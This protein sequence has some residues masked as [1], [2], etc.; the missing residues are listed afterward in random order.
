[1]G[2]VLPEMLPQKTETTLEKV[3]KTFSC[4]AKKHEKQG[5]IGKK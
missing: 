5:N 1:M 3:L 2:R 4:I